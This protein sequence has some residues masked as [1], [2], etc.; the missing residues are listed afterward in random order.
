VIPLTLVLLGM[1]AVVVLVLLLPLL[2]AWRAP[3]ERRQYD[4]AVYRAQLDELARDVARG[5]IGGA[6]AQAARVEIERR[7]LAAGSAPGSALGSTPGSAPG[8]APPDA[9]PQGV[10]PGAPAPRL[11]SNRALALA[12]ALIIAGGAGLVYLRLGAPGVPDVP[13]AERQEAA[14]AGQGPHAG[15]PPHI[16][17]AD[18]AKTLAAKLKTDPNNA[19]GWLM[20]A[21]TEAM[22]GNWQTSAD[23]YSHAIAQGQ[24]D[25]DVFAGY[26]E[27]LVLGTDGIVGPP[28][29]AAFTSAL[30]RDGKNDVARYY[31]A[32]ADA[33]AGESRRAIAGWQALAADIPDDSPM[34]EAIGRQVADAASTAGIAA[35]PLPKGQPATASTTGEPTAGEQGPGQDQMAAAENMP[36]AE[37]D[38]MVRGMVE[39]LATELASAPDNLAG[40]LQLGRAYTVL[41]YADKAADAFDHAAALKP[42]DV[43]ISMQEVEAILTNRKPDDA[44]PA[45]AVT[46]LKQIEAVSPDRPEVLW[47]LGV[48]AARAGQRDE[49]KRDWQRLLPLL[50]ADSEDRK[51]VVEALQTLDKS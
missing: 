48:V 15:Q 46:L 30:Q 14:P 4:R 27:M 9:V 28:A 6:E 32:L 8:A 49:A 26:G 19:Q 51:T 50:P 3:A 24:T 1:T 7:L 29:R 35:P 34:R 18:A 11:G 13:F 43:E 17:M 37:R 39:K 40:W 12:A 23:A 41:G 36:P 5:V 45:R 33:Q 44:I 25:A 47:Y 22:L 20:Y 21:R 31:T 10:A 2:H 42:G 16:D 38:K